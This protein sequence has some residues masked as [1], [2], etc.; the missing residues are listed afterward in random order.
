K[1]YPIKKRPIKLLQ[2]QP[3]ASAYDQNGFLK[4][5]YL[6]QDNT[7]AEKVVISGVTVLLR[8]IYG[9]IYNKLGSLDVFRIDKDSSKFKDNLENLSKYAVYNQIMNEYDAQHFK[10]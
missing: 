3:G 4:K 7:L 2:P 9:S 1:R 10:F 6:D 5:E 8:A